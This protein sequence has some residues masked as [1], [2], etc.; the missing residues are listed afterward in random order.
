[1]DTSSPFEAVLPPLYGLKATHLPE[2]LRYSTLHIQG[3]C[4]FD[5][6][7]WFTRMQILGANGKI[8]LSIPVKKHVKG[9]PLNEI[10]IDHLQ[11]WQNQHWRSIQSGYG[12]SPFFNYYKEE[13]EVLFNAAPTLLVE[14]TGPIMHWILAQYQAKKGKSVILAQ[15]SQTFYDSDPLLLVQEMD[16]STSEHLFTYTQVFGENFV[17]GL[18]VL[19]HLFCEGPKFWNL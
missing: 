15:D 7:G 14:F 2:L 8:L 1:L 3:N 16:K 18:G 10:R 6:S 11:K 9:T 13:L 4:P 5:A 12:K 19:D 17:P